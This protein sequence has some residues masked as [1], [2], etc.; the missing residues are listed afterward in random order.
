M[1]CCSPACVKLFRRLVLF[2]VLAG[3][4]FSIFAI[5]SCEFIVYTYDKEDGTETSGSAGFFQSGE[6]NNSCSLY[7]RS[8]DKSEE[9][10]KSAAI[11][12][13]IAAL[14]AVLVIIMKLSFA[15]C[16]G[17]RGT[18][19][20][21]LVAALVSQ[22]ITFIFYNS[23]E[24]CDGDILNEITH[25]DPCKPG[26]GSAF[27]ILAL[28]LY[29]FSMVAFWCLPKSSQKEVDVTGSEVEVKGNVV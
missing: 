9:V 15:S 6:D 4:V 2:F 24:F 16:K 17:S 29:F 7:D 18:V 28:I 12:A 20:L 13:P 11:F 23:D 1:V 3:V 14:F 25:L 19:V 26:K 21:C 27:S 10:A 8:F 22:G 5:T